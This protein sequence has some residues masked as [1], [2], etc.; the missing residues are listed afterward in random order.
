M[1]AWRKDNTRSFDYSTKGRKSVDAVW[2][3]ALYDELA[4]LIDEV[5][6]TIPIDLMKA[7]E[8]VPLW[9]ASGKMG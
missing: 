4:G 3:Q 2:K 7:F 6:I 5:S 9:S 1:T 8:S